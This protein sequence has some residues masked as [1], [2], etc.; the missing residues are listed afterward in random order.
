VLLL[1]EATSNLDLA[2]EAEVQKAM[3]TVARG[4]TTILVAHRL[5][6]ARTADRII[7][8]DNGRVVAEGTHDEL[9][10]AGGRYADMWEAFGTEAT[11]A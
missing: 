9:L 3:S 1:D 11:A 5:P 4:R 10:A 7:V 8:I 2:T 6:T